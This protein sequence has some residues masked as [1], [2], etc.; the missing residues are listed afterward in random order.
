MFRTS[1]DTKRMSLVR[2]AIAYS[3]IATMIGISASQWE[4]SSAQ[5]MNP[6]QVAAAIK[7]NAQAL[8]AFSWQQRTQIQL[9][10]ET[11]KV[12]INQMSYDGAGNQQKVKIS[13]QPEP[14]QSQ[15]SGGRLKQRIVQK[16]TDEF[17]EMLEGI[18]G[19]V[20]SYTEIPHEQLQTAMQKA[21]FSAGEG[22][23]N[24][25]V[26]ISMSGVIQNG[27]SFKIWIDRQA[28]LFRRVA[29][30]TTYEQKPVTVGANYAM[31]PSGEVYMAQ[32]IV[33]YPAKQVVVEID[34]MNYQRR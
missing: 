18:A 9:K 7:A 34:N 32:A 8:K 21:S 31:L 13:E 26:Q 17:K 19:L 3:I 24:G 27:D 2:R 30:N 20:K 1:M 29:I 6:S 16:K 28:M 15:P 33:N 23:M 10:G 4:R 5:G 11:K 22:E 12:V 14:G 25:A